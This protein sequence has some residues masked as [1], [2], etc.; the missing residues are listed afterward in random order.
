[1]Q[2][3]IET[4]SGLERKLTVGVPAA[5]VDDEVNSR[6]QKA[7]KDIRLDGFRPGKVPV[8]HVRR[9]HGDALMG[10]VLEETVNATSQEALE[11]DN[12]RPALQPDIE[13]TSFEQG[14]DLEYTMNV[15]IMPDIETADFSKITL[16]KEIA[17]V[18]KEIAGIDK[19]L[20][21]PKFTERAP[22]EVVEENRERK[23]GFE[24]QA[25]KLA[26]ALERLRAA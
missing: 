19:R 6:L 24:Q 21:N 12:V 17:K 4:T 1:M 7:A 2:V 9:L 8:S 11:N 14:S 15:E 18:A 22:A 13:I 16:E 25:A 26:A 20:G 23:A 3:S 5:R 10:E